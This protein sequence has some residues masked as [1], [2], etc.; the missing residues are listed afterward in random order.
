[1]V[2]LAVFGAFAALAWWILERMAAGNPRAI[3]RL[4]E[5]KSP[6]SRRNAQAESP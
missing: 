4:E 1:M 3:E 6:H 5:L 2:P